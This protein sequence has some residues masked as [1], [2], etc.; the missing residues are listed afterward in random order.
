[1]TPMA[2]INDEDDDDVNLAARRHAARWWVRGHCGDL[3]LAERYAFLQW[4]KT[5]PIHIA[6]LL[7][8]VQ[9]YLDLEAARPLFNVND[10][11]FRRVVPWRPRAH[12]RP[13]VGAEVPRWRFGVLAA[14]IIG[15]A[16]FALPMISTSPSLSTAQAEWRSLQLEDG[17][18]V[19]LAEGTVIVDQAAVKTAPPQTLRP[20]DELSISHGSAVKTRHVN[21]EHK[22]AWARRLLIFETETLREAV[23][24]YNR[25]NRLQIIIPP[26]LAQRS[27]R[28]SFHADDPRSFASSLALAMGAVVIEEPRVL[29]IELARKAAP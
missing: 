21:A 28:G 16:A 4:C 25:R 6:Q 15:I 10:D 14:A 20:G 19:T 29:R 12:S 27:V 2:D 26:S 3:S 8:T 23:A 22:L 17:S 11:E 24:E 9:L 7:K 13:T 18:S 1:M 5:S